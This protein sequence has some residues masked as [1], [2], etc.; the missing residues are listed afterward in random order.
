MDDNGNIIYYILLGVIYLLSRV[1]G[2]KK[3]PPAKPARSPQRRQAPANREDQER[4]PVQ[5][6][7]AE[8][9]PALSFEEILRELSGVPQPKPKA[10]PQPQ[11]TPALD[12]LEPETG[13]NPAP[14]IEGRPQPSYA[15][16]EMDQIAGEFKTPKPFGSDRLPEPDLAALRRKKLSFER[17]DKYSLKERRTVNYLEILKEK[18]G[19]AKAFVLGEI[20]NKKY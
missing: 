16:D 4:E 7:T 10:D 15:V 9:E 12:A 5:A 3:K 6:P 13:I 20:F 18:D 19:P 2:K 17:D 8:K 11:P 1:F 14:Q